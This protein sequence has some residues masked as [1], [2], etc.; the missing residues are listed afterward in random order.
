M[1]GTHLLNMPSMSFC[2]DAKVDARAVVLVLLERFLFSVEV[3]E[4]DRGTGEA[5]SPLVAAAMSAQCSGLVVDEANGDA[6]KLPKVV[7]L[8]TL[9]MGVREHPR[10][11]R[12]GARRVNPSLDPKFPRP[13]PASLPITSN[14]FGNY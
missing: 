8:R 11:Q 3:E 6:R 14:T 10:S 7:S 13:L 9:G 1:A 4:A 2:R 12:R 5:R